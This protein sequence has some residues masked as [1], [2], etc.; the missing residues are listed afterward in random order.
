MLNRSPDLPTQNLQQQPAFTDA[1][2]CKDWLQLVPMINIPQAHAEI[3]Q[4][5]MKLNRA[6]LVP[7][8]RLKIMETLRE[9]V[10]L[11]Q[12]EHAKRYLGKALPLAVQ[13]QAIWR[14]NVDLWFEMSIGYHICLQAGLSG[15]RDLADFTALSAQRA[16]RYAALE[17]REYYLAY[18]QVPGNLWQ[19]LHQVYLQA[20]P[21]CRQ[22]TF[23]DSLNTQTELSSCTA[24]YVQT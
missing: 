6:V 3:S 5:L 1:R 12:D 16:L 20:E 15:D 13:E 19:R 9:S 22:R 4:E 8:D 2:G 14:Q 17:I 24:A 7:F 11:L 10:S 23:K 18:Q 21:T